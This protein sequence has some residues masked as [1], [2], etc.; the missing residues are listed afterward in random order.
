MGLKTQ[1][2]A[3][4]K[5]LKQDAVRI[6]E[7]EDQVHG[8]ESWK[9]DCQEEIR[10]AEDANTRLQSCQDAITAL[11]QGLAIAEHRT[12]LVQLSFKLVLPLLEGEAR[13]LISLMNRTCTDTYS[14]V[15]A[16][17][18]NAQCD[19]KMEEERQENAKKIGQLLPGGGEPLT[20]QQ[21]IEKQRED[22][23]H[24]SRQQT[25]HMVDVFPVD[26]FRLKRAKAEAA[27][28]VQATAR[29]DMAKVEDR[30]A[31]K[32]L[33]RKAKKNYKLT[34]KGRKAQLAGMRRYWSDFHK[35]MKR[36]AARNK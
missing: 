11:E 24:V 13:E 6:A 33:K 19:A 36:R 12:K 29:E 35:S 10:R 16:E 1:N 21:R 5:Q 31:V 23:R 26:Q 20:V 4:Q 18:I 34:A 28:V 25:A 22:L 15:Q 17:K 7:L 9:E 3:Y 14:A 2:R 30:K 8:L 32:T 27:A